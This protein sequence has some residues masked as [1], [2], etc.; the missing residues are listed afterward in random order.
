MN[1]S[2]SLPLGP[3]GM[4]K[5]ASSTATIQIA[6]NSLLLALKSWSG[7][8]AFFSEQKGF[9]SVINMIEPTTDRD[10][11]LSILKMLFKLLG[12]DPP[13]YEPDGDSMHSPSGSSYLTMS[14]DGSIC[15]NNCSSYI[16]SVS[17]YTDHPLYNTSPIFNDNTNIVTVYLGFIVWVLIQS[18]LIDNISETV[19]SADAEL[20][21]YLKELY[22]IF[23]ILNPL[24]IPG[25]NTGNLITKSVEPAKKAFQFEGSV[26]P[27]VLDKVY[28]ARSFLKEA[29]LKSSVLFVCYEE[30]PFQ[31]TQSS[32]FF[33][34]VNMNL[35]LLDY[36]NGNDTILHHDSFFKDTE[37]IN[38]YFVQKD[39]PFQ[40][41]ALTSFNLFQE[42]DIHARQF[43]KV[44]NVYLFSIRSIT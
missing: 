9:H 20:L 25:F 13:T 16:S 28:K 19:N 3:P 33:G 7:M 36:V 42:E 10:V 8:F 2:S 11:L 14:S 18:Q 37:D 29:D 24:L 23:S 43:F 34:D 38:L 1:A 12:M 44:A 21:F 4:A 30:K 6:I 15:W 17:C 26:N 31:M 32:S 41:L 40:N 5:P 39:I 27:V 22:K 35:S